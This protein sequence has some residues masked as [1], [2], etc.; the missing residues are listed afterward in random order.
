MMANVFSP[1][2]ILLY[3]FI[4]SADFV[5]F[6]SR[7]RHRFTPQ[8]TQNVDGEPVGILKRTFGYAYRVRLVGKWIKARSRFACYCVKFALL[9]AF[10]HWIFLK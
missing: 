7:I 5:H 4:V 2:P 1:R 6:R 3:A 10:S 9:G 8:L